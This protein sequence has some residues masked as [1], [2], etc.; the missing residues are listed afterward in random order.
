MTFLRYRI[1]L[2]MTLEIGIVLKGFTFLHLLFCY[3]FY[4]GT[5]L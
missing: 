4:M 5:L 2:E 3:N 1:Y